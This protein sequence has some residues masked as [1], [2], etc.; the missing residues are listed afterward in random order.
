MK[1]SNKILTGTYLVI[2]LITITTM[3]FVRNGTTEREPLKSIGE[4][5]T[6]SVNFKYLRALD[7]AVGNVTLIQQEGPSHIE[8]KCAENIRQH[9]VQEF[10][11]NEFYLGIDGDGDDDLGI[12]VIVYIDDIQSI[13]ISGRANLTSNATFKTDS[14]LIKT[15]SASAL[16]MDVESD[17]LKVNASNASRVNLSGTTN[18]LKV[19]AQ[20]AG[21]VE[22]KNLIAKEVDA[23]AGNAG[24]MNIH[25]SEK[26]SVDINNAGRINYLGHPQILKNSV[27]SGGSLNSINPTE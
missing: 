25:A 17:F 4:S 2:L 18:F 10:E 12:E 9:L 19:N 6:E 14:L 27:N 1:T 24:H 16:E 22:A 11:D 13:T 5:T 26:L 23:Y 7:I 20:N 15:Y 3:A 8:I 21:R